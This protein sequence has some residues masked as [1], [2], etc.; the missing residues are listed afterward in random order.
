MSF[1]EKL[2]EISERAQIQRANL[3]TE[4]AMKTAILL[5]MFQALEYDFSDPTEVIP[6]YTADVGI[7]K[8]EKVDYALCIDGKVVILVECKAPNQSLDLKH[9]SQLYRYFSVTDA[10]FAILT[11]GFDWEFYTDLDQPN[12]MDS[13]PFLAFGLADIDATSV[14]ELARFKRSVFDV[15]NI[16]KTATDLKYVSGLKA[17]VRQELDEP[18]AE[19]V[20]FFG[21]KIY[22][23]MFT[24]SVQEQFTR[25]LKRSLSEVVRDR[26]NARLKSALQQNFVDAE[27]SDPETPDEIETT[28]DEWDGYR[29]A[30]AI[31]SRVIDPSRIVIRD[32]KS[33]CGV[34]VDDNNRKPLVRL[35][36]N[37]SNVRYLGLFDG[38]IEEKVRI[39]GPTD[40]YRFAE[41][42]CA[43]A[44]KYDPQP[45][46]S[47]PE[48]SSPLTAI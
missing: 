3:L 33:Y 41:R 1:E 42:I 24:A 16:L 25:L 19:F 23:G 37:S 35:W 18:S 10:R 22:E 48:G 14:A 27:P 28:E 40:L 47:P 32:Q 8:G 45:D 11:N 17:A 12:R 5:K 34:L 38:D 9:A 39:S 31:A 29:V 21:R 36:F 13:R 15:E 43:T 46:A 7:K 30:V 20:K 4:E 44:K 6:E 2:R 26:V